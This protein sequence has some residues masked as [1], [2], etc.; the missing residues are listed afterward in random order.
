MRVFN[1]LDMSKVPLP[2]TITELDFEQILSQ[3]KNKLLEHYPQYQEALSFES[4]PMQ[5]MLEMLAYQQLLFDGKLNDAIKGNML[6]SATGN[7][8]DAIAARYNVDRQDKESDERFRRRT[9][10]VFEGLNTAGSKQAYQFHA[11]SADPRVKDVYVTSPEPCDIH[12]TILSHEQNGEPSDD[13]LKTLKQH[14]GLLPTGNIAKEASKV[15]PL[16]DRVT[17]TGPDIKHFYL[18]VSINIAPGPAASVVEHTV[19]AALA[20]YLAQQ[21]L[22]GRDINHMGLF[23][24]LNQPGVESGQIIS[25]IGDISIGANQVAICDSMTVQSSVVEA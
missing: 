12:L 9:Q 4:E 17:I 18:A 24:A 10:M 3:L 1:L 5:V 13:L 23:A 15:R 25:P 16:G 14:F 22:L 11:L 8:L 7:D 21:T 20:Q 19:K 6:A 2:D